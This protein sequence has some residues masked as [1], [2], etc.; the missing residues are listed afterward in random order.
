MDSQRIAALDLGTNTTRLLVADVRGKLVTEV[1][2]RSE[3]T[4][5][6]E[7]VDAS[8]RL[9]PAAMERVMSTLSEYRDAIDRHGAEQ[10]VA[11]ATSAI[12][13]ASN[14]DE[15]LA[16][17]ASRFGIEART[18]SGD[19]EARLTFAGATSAR[20]ADGPLLVLDIGGGS[21]EFVVGEAGGEPTFHVSTRAGSVRQSERHLSQDPPSRE[22]LTALSEEVGAIVRA[23]VPESVRAA[24]T[25]GIAVAG[26]AT[27]LAAI[28]QQ[29]EPYDPSKVDGYVLQLAGCE[30]M[31][32]LLAE[33]PLERRRQVPGLHPDR[34]P[35]IVAGAAILIEAMRACGLDSIETSEADILYGAALSVANSGE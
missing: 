27:S 17:I 35:M 16:D 9:A 13:D 15:L 32:S 7:G 24:V 22:D 1:E 10:T 8:G 11:V 4:R 29:L 21:T 26:T 23:D 33:L 31:L 34:A 6:G 14:G 18:I 30:Q 2:R 3:V 28:D 5:L 20:Q 19:E 25:K 12:R